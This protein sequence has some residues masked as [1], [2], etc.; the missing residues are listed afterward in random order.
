M[1]TVEQIRKRIGENCKVYG[2]VKDKYENEYLVA[3]KENKRE[4]DVY[5]YSAIVDKPDVCSLFAVWQADD[6]MYIRDIQIAECD[7]D[8][9]LGSIAMKYF[10]NYVRAHNANGV[11]GWLSWVDK[12]HFDRS[13][14]FYQKHGF[15]VKFNED[16]TEGEIFMNLDNKTDQVVVTEKETILI[17]KQEAPEQSERLAAYGNLLRK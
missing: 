9:G 14:R 1:T 4:V 17:E 6:F 13:E 11:R 12:D 8:Q 10:L 2:P 15:E 16:R 7:C 3:I 5:L